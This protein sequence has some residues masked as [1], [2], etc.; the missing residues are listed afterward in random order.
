[1]LLV[2]ESPLPTEHLE[3]RL[4]PKSLKIETRLEQP[5]PRRLQEKTPNP[6][7]KTP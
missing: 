2:D 6:Q 3:T 7:Y 5:H 1:M 4:Q